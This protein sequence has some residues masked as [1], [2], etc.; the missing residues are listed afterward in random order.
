MKIPWLR[1]TASQNRRAV[2]LL[3]R[4]YLFSVRCKTRWRVFDQSTL[5]GRRS[6]RSA[7]LSRRHTVRDSVGD[8]RQ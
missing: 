4:P 7:R 1:G 3:L 8:F 6:R 5:R 2:L